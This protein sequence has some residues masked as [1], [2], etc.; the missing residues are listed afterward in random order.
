MV[1]EFVVLCASA[2]PA[3]VNEYANWRRVKESAPDAMAWKA[4]KEASRIHER[5]WDATRCDDPGR[6]RRMIDECTLDLLNIISVI[7]HELAFLL[8]RH[9][10]SCLEAVRNGEGAALG[11]VSRTALGAEGNRRPR[12]RRP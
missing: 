4:L 8:I 6:G 2:V 10:D 9:R 3:L 11:S 7:P 1:P 5:C 12:H